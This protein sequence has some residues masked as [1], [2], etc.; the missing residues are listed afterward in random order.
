MLKHN[1]VHLVS[2][3]NPLI[4]RPPHI[5]SGRGLGTPSTQRSHQRKIP[6]VDTMAVQ[7]ADWRWQWVIRIASHIF[8]PIKITVS[9][10]NINNVIDDGTDAS[11][12]K[13]GY[14]AAHHKQVVRWFGFINLGFTTVKQQQVTANYKYDL[15]RHLNWYTTLS[16][17]IF[18]AT[19]LGYS[20]QSQ[21]HMPWLSLALN[22]FPVCHI[23]FRQHHNSTTSHKFLHFRRNHQNCF[24]FQSNRSR[25]SVYRFNFMQA[26]VRACSIVLIATSDF[27]SGSLQQRWA[28]FL[29]SRHLVRTSNRFHLPPG[30]VLTPVWCSVE[31][32]LPYLILWYS[33][34][35]FELI[36]STRFGESQFS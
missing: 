16:F 22:S 25:S 33:L 1:S 3:V 15:D 20:R 18:A 28:L 29:I 34:P 36:I 19:S 7:R 17:I 5:I 12:N 8:T 35:C 9:A 6:I 23:A 10:Q 27:L 21:M 13:Y 4:G 14:P 26:L 2:L 11:N 32:H 24:S 31:L 30:D